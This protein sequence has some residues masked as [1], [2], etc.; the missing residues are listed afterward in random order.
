MYFQYACRQ[1]SNFEVVYLSAGHSTTQGTDVAPVPVSVHIRYVVVVIFCQSV[2]K[3]HCMLLR[4]LRLQRAEPSI[5]LQMERRRSSPGRQ[6]QKQVSQ[7]LKGASPE[8]GEVRVASPKSTSKARSE[9]PPAMDVFELSPRHS[10]EARHSDR[11]VMPPLPAEPMLGLAPP[12]PNRQGPG[13]AEQ[14]KQLEARCQVR[15][16]M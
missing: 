8:E 10:W 2:T 5:F 4:Q 15:F 3:S 14:E 9:T 1:D 7:Q 16:K 13:L 11:D 12:L 6:R